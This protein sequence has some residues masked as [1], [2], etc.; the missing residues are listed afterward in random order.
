VATLRE[1][2]KVRA[3]IRPNMTSD[4]RSTGDKAVTATAGAGVEPEMEVAINTAP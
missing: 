3:M 1:P 4:T 2:V